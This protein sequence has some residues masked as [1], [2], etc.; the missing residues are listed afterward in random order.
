[1]AKK[2]RNTKAESTSA[3]TFTFF[4]FEHRG[5]PLLPPNVFARRMVIIALIDIAAILLWVFLGMLGYIYTAHLKPI[6]AFLNACMIAG[7]MGPVQNMDSSYPYGGAKLFAGIYAV[8]SG[9]LILAVFGVLAAPVIHRIMHRFH[10]EPEEEGTD[11]GE[12]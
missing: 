10:L 12:E 5:Q 3:E 11:K 2:L 7:G 8:L 9:M 4:P 1:M 6:D